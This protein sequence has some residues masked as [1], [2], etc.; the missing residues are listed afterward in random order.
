MTLPYVYYDG[1]SIISIEPAKGIQSDSLFK[2]LDIYT[3]LMLFTCIP[4]SGFALYLTRRFGWSS[5]RRANFCQCCWEVVVI[6]CW[7]TVTIRRSPWPVL[8]VF[9]SY[10]LMTFIVITEYFGMYT[11]IIAVQ[12]YVTPPIDTPEQLWESNKK[13]V[14][15]PSSISYFLEYFEDVKD[16]DD[17]RYYSDEIKRSNYP[18]VEAL[19]HVM[20]SKGE[21]VYFGTAEDARYEIDS[22]GLEENTTH[23]YYYSKTQFDPHFT[24]LYYRPPC[25]FREHL[26]RAILVLEA[27]NIHEIEYLDYIRLDDIRAAM[28]KPVPPTDYGL[29][30]LEHLVTALLVIAGVLVASIISFIIEMITSQWLRKRRRRM[31]K[32]K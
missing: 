24:V 22:Y 30:Q 23:K 21:V 18:T 32:Q 17:R 27:M 28:S 19:D 6:I 11:A 9:S 16:I 12:K 4:L 31:G 20:S 10:L 13:W 14:T 5:D 15:D 3:W 2:A 26:N 29:I 8:F 7:E 25:F 1:T